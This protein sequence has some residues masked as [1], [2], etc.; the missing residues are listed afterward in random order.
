M[1]R[2]SRC[3]IAAR[4]RLEGKGSV[5]SMFQEYNASFSTLAADNDDDDDDFAGE[6][7]CWAS[8]VSPLKV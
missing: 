4:I 7:C 3:A 2:S 1:I 8:Q 5:M 6:E